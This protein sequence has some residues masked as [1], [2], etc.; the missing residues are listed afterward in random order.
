MLAINLQHL[1]KELSRRLMILLRQR[2]AGYRNSSV[3]L[4]SEPAFRAKPIHELLDLAFGQRAHESI[5]RLAVD[6]GENRRDGLH[7]H[8]RGDL[9]VFIDVDLDQL[10]LAVGGLDNFLKTGAKLLAGATP[11]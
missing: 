2:S 1:G 3:E 9:L 11:W 4:F 10:H 8:L 5:H 6:E 7:A